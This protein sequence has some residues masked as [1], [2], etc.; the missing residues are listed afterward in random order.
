MIQPYETTTVNTLAVSC[1]LSYIVFFC[2]YSLYEFLYSFSELTL[3]L[4]VLLT[5]CK[6]HFKVNCIFLLT[7]LYIHVI[8]IPV[9]QTHY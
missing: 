1:F 3:Y 7:E 8:K 2:D 5:L 9:L 6:Y 4:F